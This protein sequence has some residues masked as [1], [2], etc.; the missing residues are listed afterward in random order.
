MDQFNE[1]AGVASSNLDYSF[2]CPITHT[3]TLFPVWFYTA[4]SFS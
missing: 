4:A 3:V 2:L 1:I